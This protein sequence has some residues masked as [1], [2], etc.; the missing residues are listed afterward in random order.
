MSVLRSR[1]VSGNQM[2]TGPAHPDVGSLPAT[3]RVTPL[4]VITYSPSESWYNEIWYQPPST[5][6]PN[7]VPVAALM[8]GSMG[9]VVPAGRA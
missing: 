7:A 3:P 9:A 1:I 5:G 2:A 4:A 6:D 8:R